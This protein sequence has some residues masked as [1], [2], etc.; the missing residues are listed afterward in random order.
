MSEHHALGYARGA[1]GVGDEG[2]V[3]LGVD[4]GAPEVYDC[5]GVLYCGVMAEAKSAGGADEN[6][7]GLWNSG[8]SC[9]GS[10]NWKQF[11]YCRKGAGFRTLQLEG[12]FLNRIT[13]NHRISSHSSISKQC[14]N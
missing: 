14:R 6:D 8:G 11:C 1:G 13:L 9:G 5:G 3:G 4:L 10:R 12:Q 7:V 2:E